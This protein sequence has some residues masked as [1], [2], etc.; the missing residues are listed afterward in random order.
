ML[1]LKKLKNEVKNKIGDLNM[2]NYAGE[3]TKKDFKRDEK[4]HKQMMERRL[5]RAEDRG[6]NNVEL[7]QMIEMGKVGSDEYGGVLHF[8]NNFY[9]NLPGGD[10]RK[11]TEELASKIKGENKDIERLRGMFESLD[12]AIREMGISPEEGER[13]YLEIKN[14]SDNESFVKYKELLVKLYT[15][16]RNFGYSHKELTS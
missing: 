11:T 2:D 6:L 14:R 5:R 10:H 9:S 16:M 15:K 8:L 3:Y 7:S 4:N 13:I 12:I 1:Y